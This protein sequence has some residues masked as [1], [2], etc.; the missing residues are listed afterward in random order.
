MTPDGKLPPD[1]L[2]VI[3]RPASEADTA[4]VLE[5][6]RNIWDG[7]DYVPQVWV[8]WLEDP[9]G[10][11]I[12]AEYA[13][14]V[15][16]LGKLSRL[17]EADWWLQG[18]RVHPEFEGRGVASQLHRAL[19]ESWEA[20][21]NGKLRLAT[22]SFRKP[23]QHLCEQSGFEKV[24]Q[25]T[26]FKAEALPPGGSSGP[27]HFR[28]LQSAE[29]EE[30]LYQALKSETLNASRGHIDLGWEW[31]PLRLEHLMR[32]VEEKRLWWWKGQSGLIA[33]YR[34][35]EGESE[36]ALMLSFSACRISVLP[37]LLLDFRRL[38][39]A[40]GF[41][42]AGWIASLNPGLMEGLAKAGFRRGWDASMYVYEKTHASRP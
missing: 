22:A 10:A 26:P 25:F 15:I 39:G 32:A 14:R 12:A 36:P 13:G 8:E 24:D 6:T 1:R 34:D 41:S 21:G 38:A 4:D 17:S 11:L 37:Q 31:L 2:Q 33:A 42:K 27:D 30:A 23:V 3:C 19:V 35:L 20:T 5:L 16:G 28:S 18:L 40:E 29:L 9:Q 7:E